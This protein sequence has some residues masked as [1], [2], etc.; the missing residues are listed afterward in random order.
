[1]DMVADREEVPRDGRGW[2]SGELA[3]E[4][5]AERRAVE[6]QR[7]SYAHSLGYACRM[8][9]RA[10][11]TAGQSRS[12]TAPYVEERG[13]HAVGSHTTHKGKRAQAEAAYGVLDDWMLESPCRLARASVPRLGLAAE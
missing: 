8:R 11:C 5:A 6:I 2:A 9:V 3:K 12:T 13:T 7:G 10:P 4:V 1:M